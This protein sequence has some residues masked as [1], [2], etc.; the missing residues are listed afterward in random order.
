MGYRR[1]KG[2]DDSGAAYVCLWGK[3]NVDSPQALIL[4]QFFPF[5]CPPSL[6]SLKVSPEN[7]FSI[8]HI[9]PNPYLRLYFYGISPGHLTYEETLNILHTPAN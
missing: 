6:T 8:N 5:P 4:Y 9:H 3:A 2:T 1:L 7:G